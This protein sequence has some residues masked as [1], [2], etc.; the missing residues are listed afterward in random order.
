MENTETTP[1]SNKPNTI[2]L[3]KNRHLIRP[4]A[5]TA[6]RQLQLE[7]REQIG[8]FYDIFSFFIIIYK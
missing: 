2:V 6:R 7:A 1:A 3:D 4:Y 5:E 8:K